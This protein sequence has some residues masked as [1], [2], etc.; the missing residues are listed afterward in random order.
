MLKTRNH[1]K[2]FEVEG[3]C[4]PA[5]AP[6]KLWVL[7]SLWGNYPGDVSFAVGIALTRVAQVAESPSSPP[8]IVSLKEE[9]P[10]DH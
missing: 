2:M 9:S 6:I 4:P 8:G 7:S 1:H 10:G 3:P 5:R